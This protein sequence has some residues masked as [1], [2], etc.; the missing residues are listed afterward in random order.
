MSA[1]VGRSRLPLLSVVVP[2]LEEARALPSLI[3]DLARLRV[4][5]EIIVADGGS[6]DGTQAGAAALG[7]RVV[8]TA[9]GRGSQLRAGAAVARGRVLCFLHADVRL[10]GAALRALERAVTLPDDVVLAFTLRIAAS[11]WRYRFV[12]WGTDRRARWGRLPYGDQGLVLTR[13]T[14]E[15]AGGFPPI[16]LMEDVVFVRRLR[17]RAEVRILPER[18]AVSPRRWQKDGVLR[19]MLRNWLLLTA[20]LVGIPPARLT[21][22]YQPWSGR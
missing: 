1:D 14:Y 3:A 15:E 10:D 17:G 7:A 5:H 21:P 6:Q 20:Y 8:D 19:R 9:R 22:A 12:E 2:T 18:I 16:P 13:A 4:P 11:G